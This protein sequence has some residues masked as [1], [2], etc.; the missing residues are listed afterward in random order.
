MT[1]DFNFPNILWENTTQPYLKITEK[2]FYNFVKDMGLIQLVKTP[3]RKN[4]ILDLIITDQNNMISNVEVIAP[5]SFSDH[6][7]VKFSINFSDNMN[8]QKK[9]V[10]CFSKCN[11]DNFN[12]ELANIDWRSTFSYF[13]NFDELYYIFTNIISEN[14]SKNLCH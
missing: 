8:Q 3:T 10:K 9:L 4:N 7:S 11:F 1:G 13:K 12:S 5:F 6:N 14:I 2:C